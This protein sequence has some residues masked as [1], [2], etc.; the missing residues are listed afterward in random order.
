M[1]HKLGKTMRMAEI[2]A[3][4]GGKGAG[5][6]TLAN[7]LVKN[8]GFTNIKFA[9]PIK[10]ALSGI[11]GFNERQ[12][13]GDLKEVRDERYGTS[14]RVIMQWFGTD[15]MQYG[16]AS[17]APDIGRRFWS[18]KLKVQIDA[19]GCNSKIVISDLR[20]SHELEM[21]RE[22]Y[23]ERLTV[24][25]IVRPVDEETLSEVDVHE[26]EANC[27]NLCVDVQI[28]NSGTPAELYTRS[29]KQLVFKK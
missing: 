24:I 18:D 22:N 28:E 9:R 1:L 13:D 26:S 4:C 12:L 14:P 16:L 7:E 20:F 3:L 19:L 10:D 17:V 15:V 8:D 23:P 27:V 2:I 25:R 11:F 6:D 5:K 21:L 29:K